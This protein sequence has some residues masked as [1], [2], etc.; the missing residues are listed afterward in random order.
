MASAHRRP[1]VRFDPFEVDLET[2]ELR[3]AAAK[4]RLQE[5]PFQILAMLLERAG[6]LV[7]REELRQRIW[8]DA[9]F[10]DFEH[11]LNKA[12]NKLR[13]ALGDVA[14]RPSFVETLPRR[15]YRFIAPVERL[16]V[17]RPRAAF[18]VLYEERSIALA[19]G[20]NL[21]GRD[22]AA[23]VL[24]DASSVSRRHARILVSADGVCIEDLESKNGT[25]VRERRV[26]APTPLADG[27]VIRVGTV[28]MQFR[29]MTVAS[30]QTASGG[31]ILP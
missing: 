4:V 25:F 30:T 16:G 28:V 13:K 20:W 24:V 6:D 15:G 31:P 8:P 29:A 9:V 19:P 27:D 7:T 1:I 22:A 5:Q 17:K 11:G 23:T 26:K 3:R 2:G 18:R 21:I 12:V 14:E 10:I